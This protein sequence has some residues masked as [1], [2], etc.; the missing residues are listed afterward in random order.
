[1]RLS[2]L[3][4]LAAFASSAAAHAIIS[5]S[6]LRP[7]IVAASDAVAP[8]ANVPVFTRGPALYEPRIAAAKRKTT[9]RRLAK[10]TTTKRKPARKTTKRV[11]Q[12]GKATTRKTTTRKS[13]STSTTTTQNDHDDIKDPNDAC[14][15]FSVGGCHLCRHNVC[16]PELKRD[17]NDYHDNLYF[18]NDCISNDCISSGTDYILV[19]GRLQQQS[20]TTNQSIFTSTSASTSASPSSSSSTSTNRLTGTPAVFAAAPYPSNM[21]GWYDFNGTSEYS[22][23]H[24]TIW[25]STEED[26]KIGLQIVEATYDCFVNQQGWRNPGVSIYDDPETGPFYKVNIFTT[27][28]VPSAG[29][30]GVA[31]G[32]YNTGL[33]FFFLIPEVVNNS[34]TPSHEFGHVLTWAQNQWWNQSRAMGWAET[35]AQYVSMAYQ[36]HP[37]CASS[38]AAYNQSSGWGFWPFY[39]AVYTSYSYNTLIDSTSP[40]NEYQAWPWL[41]YLHDNPDAYPSLGPNTMLNLFKAYKVNSNETPFHTLS[42]V[43]APQTSQDL[44]ARYWARMAFV[45]FTTTDYWQYVWNVTRHRLDYNNTLLESEGVWRVQEAKRPLYMGASIVPLNVTG[46][47]VSLRVDASAVFTATLAVRSSDNTVK[48]TVLSNTTAKG[49]AAFAQRVSVAVGTGQE[50]MLVVANTPNDLLLYETHDLSGSVAV[51]L[52]WSAT[53]SGAV[54]MTSLAQMTPACAYQRTGCRPVPRF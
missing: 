27:P 20:L 51:G 24:F 14:E 42:R 41:F 17:I 15:F 43:A 16:D 39:P 2:G 23:P 4:C 6:E 33:G 31:T 38:R 8:V 35:I 36:V 29:A 1:M 26:T 32:D 22:S 53:I 11:T 18:I 45:D 9:A 28:N 50:A 37:I 21:K 49:S 25:N 44:V 52:D 5:A 54:P 7:G 46:G 12:K 48:Y 30:S 19:H 10:K 40:G 3:S 34:G 13:S 47:E